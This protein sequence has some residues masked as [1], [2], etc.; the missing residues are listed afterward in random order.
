MKTFEFTL[1]ETARLRVLVK[2]RLKRS[3]D[4]EERLQLANILLKLEEQ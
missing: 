2:T 4:A 1:E 3:V